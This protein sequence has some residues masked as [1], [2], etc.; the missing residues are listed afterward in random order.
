MELHNGMKV[1]IKGTD[2]IGNVTGGNFDDET[3]YVRFQCSGDIL[4]LM[5]DVEEVKEN[6][7]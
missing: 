1:R 2:I 3:I 4:L 7:D 5:K 6:D